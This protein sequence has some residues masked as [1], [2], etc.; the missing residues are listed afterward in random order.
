MVGKFDREVEQNINR[1]AMGTG[2]ISAMLGLGVIV[3]SY[4]VPSA[5]SNGVR[6]HKETLILGNARR[7][8]SSRNSNHNRPCRANSKAHTFQTDMLHFTKELQPHQDR[9]RPA[10]LPSRY[11]PDAS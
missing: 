9:V 4:A 11:H 5:T 1:R 10:E 6:K 2:F 3:R 7:G 8:K